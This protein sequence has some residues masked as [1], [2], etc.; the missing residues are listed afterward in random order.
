MGCCQT[1]SNAE[2]KNEIHTQ[3]KS[4]PDLCEDQLLASVDFEAT[5]ID[6][7]VSRSELPV[8][9][10]LARMINMELRGLV[11]AVPGG[12]QKQRRS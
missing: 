3:K 5:A 6:T 2:Q 7:V 1:A 12:Y 4:T 9:V 8:E 11:R 10:V